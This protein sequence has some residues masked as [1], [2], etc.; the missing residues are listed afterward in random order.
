MPFD[1]NWH[2][3]GQGWRSVGRR[4]N[5]HQNIVM[6]KL[7]IVVC[8]AFK[9]RGPEFETQP[10]SGECTLP[11]LDSG[12]PVL[13]SFNGHTMVQAAECHRIGPAA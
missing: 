11:R 6:P 8:R 7:L 13:P 1:T 9:V 10:S 3:S 12:H 2:S 5:F 4:V